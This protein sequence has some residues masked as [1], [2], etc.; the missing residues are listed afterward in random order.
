MH[1]L[2][3]ELLAMGVIAGLRIDG[4]MVSPLIAIPAVAAITITI[5]AAITA[6]LKRVPFVRQIVP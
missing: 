1:V 5:S 3:L 4:R 2:V 6:T